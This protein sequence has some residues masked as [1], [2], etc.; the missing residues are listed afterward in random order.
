M[1][2]W[3]ERIAQRAV[4]KAAAEGKLSGLAGEGRP[5]DPERL[6]ETA[7]DVL[8]RM[9]ADGGFLPQEVTLA[10]DIEAKRGVLAQIE[11]E[12]ERKALQRQ[13]AL[14]EMKRNIA[15]DA[16]RKFAGD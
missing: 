11:D 1:A 8:H 15:I 16:R 6:R 9:M 13:I 2:H 3:F 14:M 12:A 4:D 10:R 7:E 5:L